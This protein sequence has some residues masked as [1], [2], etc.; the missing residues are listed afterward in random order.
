MKKS[1]MTDEQLRAKLKKCPLW[2]QDLAN[3]A[4]R[5]RDQ[6]CAELASHYAEQKPTPFFEEH[7]K[8]GGS[9][10]QYFNARRMCVEHA[11]ILLEIQVD[12]HGGRDGKAITLR[13]NRPGHLGTGT[14]IGLLPR[15]SGEFE[16]RAVENMDRRQRPRKTPRKKS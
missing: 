6:A 11:G 5:D 7:F 15:M 16:L 14:E 3:E 4:L 2:I 8:V 1:R 10:R 12:D 9:T 13:F